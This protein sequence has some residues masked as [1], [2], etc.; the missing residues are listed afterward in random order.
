MPKAILHKHTHSKYRKIL[1]INPLEATYRGFIE[2]CNDKAECTAVFNDL[3][4]KLLDTM[5]EPLVTVCER[6]QP[7]H[8]LDIKLLVLRS[9]I[10]ENNLRNRDG[11]SHR[12]F[13]DKIDNFYTEKINVWGDDFENEGWRRFID[14]KTEEDEQ[15][16]PP[17]APETP[18]YTWTPLVMKLWWILN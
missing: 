2:Q 1:K 11:R 13:W 16:V 7:A 4:L 14:E 17:P 15:L 18:L 5:N 3:R 10:R 12:A 8:Y 6:F 9:Y